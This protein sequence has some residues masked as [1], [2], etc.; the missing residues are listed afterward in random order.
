M[1]A[2]FAIRLSPP[3]DAQVGKAPDGDNGC[4]IDEQVGLAR[5]D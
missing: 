3:G 2:K 4:I 5:G 1:G